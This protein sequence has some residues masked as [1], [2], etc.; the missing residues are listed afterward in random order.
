MVKPVYTRKII[1]PLTARPRLWPPFVYGAK[2]ICGQPVSRIPRNKIARLRTSKRY[3][4]AGDR[5]WGSAR[6]SI[7]ICLHPNRCSLG[8]PSAISEAS[9]SSFRYVLAT[10]GGLLYLVRAR[11]DMY[12]RFQT[13]FPRKLLV[14][15]VYLVSSY[16]R[17]QIG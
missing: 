9:G 3:E 8:M 14:R 12:L 4:V 10:L 17:H 2:V 13:Y 11:P 7:A 5:E 16:P 6:N 15:V 1:A